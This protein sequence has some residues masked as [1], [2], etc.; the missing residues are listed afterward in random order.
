MNHAGIPG[1]THRRLVAAASVAVVTIAIVVIGGLRIAPANAAVR[2]PRQPKAGPG[3]S[4]TPFK[5]LRV[6]QGG[7]GYHAR[8]IR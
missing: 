7:S 3:G 8:E 4:A 2:Q 5:G 6:M 1:A